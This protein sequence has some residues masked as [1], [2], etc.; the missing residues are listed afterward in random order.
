MFAL[1]RSFRMR[2]AS[3]INV[4]L[5]IW[6][7]ASPWVFDYS[8]RAPVLSGVFGGALIAML[9]AI[10]LASLRERPGLSHINLLLGF[11][12]IVSPWASGYVE[13]KAAVANNIMVG[14]LVTALAV[15]ST[16][17]P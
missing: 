12:T 6:L 13:N 3:S 5:G 17:A 1:S 11:W 9:A 16:R 14:V 15:W 7:I 10:R 8:G 2:I 4:A